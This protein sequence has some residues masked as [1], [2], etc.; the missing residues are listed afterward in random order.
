MANELHVIELIPAYALGCLEAEEAGAVAGHLADCAQCRA[1]L[2]T[3]QE[4]VGEIAFSVPQFEPPPRVKAG[5]MA[6]L[7]AGAQTP[8]PDWQ[9]PSW[10]QRFASALA[11]L[12]P[13]WAVA[14]LALLAILGVSNLL[15]WGEVRELRASQPPLRVVTLQGVG[16]AP[17]AIGMVV[18]SVDGASGTLV[19]DRLPDLGEAQQYQLWLIRDSQRTS[20]GVFSVTS[21]GYGWLWIHS[22][23]PLASYS[24]F[25]ITIEPAG[26]SPGPTGERVLGGDL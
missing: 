1:D 26:G 4:V 20:G 16:N 7:Q 11:N 14:S 9:R 24:G 18:M 22:T 25:G 12:S 5:L 6:R 3:Y 13:A 8:Q 19:V 17:Q 21:D 15:L 23:Q 10:R 2:Q